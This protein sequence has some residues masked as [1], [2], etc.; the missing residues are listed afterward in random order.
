M[1]AAFI[2]VLFSRPLRRVPPIAGPL[3]LAPVGY[4]TDALFSVGSV[5]TDWFPWLTFGGVVGLEGR[6]LETSAPPRRMPDGIQGLV[7]ALSA[8]ACAAALPAYFANDQ[9][10]LSARYLEA[11]R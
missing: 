1:R 6:R 9:A 4:E 7:I 5:A 8:V 2:Y 11:R 10:G 3:L